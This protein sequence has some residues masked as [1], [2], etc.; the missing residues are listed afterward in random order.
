M[1]RIA[2]LLLGA[3]ILITCK[4]N[5]REEIDQHL[6]AYFDKG[7]IPAAVMGMADDKGDTHFYAFG[8]AVWDRKMTLVQEGDFRIQS[9]RARMRGACVPRCFALPALSRVASVRAQ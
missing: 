5:P 4:P 9:R 2:C 3:L 1:K 8:P 7:T 6:H